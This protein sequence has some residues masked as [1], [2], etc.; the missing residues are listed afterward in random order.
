M[1]PDIDDL[2]ITVITCD[3]THRIIVEHFLNLR[4]SFGNV[5]LF[6]LR[7]DDITEVEAQASLKCHAV[8]KVLDI[9]KEL[10]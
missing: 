8:T 5:F 1:R 9:I 4:V 6:L 7:N 10:G 2:I 3:E